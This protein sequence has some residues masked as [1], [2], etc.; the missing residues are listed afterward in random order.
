MRSRQRNPSVVSRMS[1][2]VDP[3]PAIEGQPVTV[4][5]DQP[6]AYYWR[7]PGGDWQRIPIDPETNSGSLTPP[8]GSGGSILDVSNLAAP[9]PDNLEVQVNSLD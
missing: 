4:K 6:G 7:T 2:V 3:N 9:N 5:V 8:P 1:I